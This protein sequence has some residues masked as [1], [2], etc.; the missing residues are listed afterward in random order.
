MSHLKFHLFPESRQFLYFL[1]LW[2]GSSGNWVNYLTTS[3]PKEIAWWN[4][5][6]NVMP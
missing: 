6:S 1:E 3:I 5:P 4:F 2:R